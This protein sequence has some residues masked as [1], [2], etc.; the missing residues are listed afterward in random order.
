[1]LSSEGS[2]LGAIPAILLSE[3]ELE[4]CVDNW[5]QGCAAKRGGN[6]ESKTSLQFEA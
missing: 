4:T 5:S 3:W 2:A 6:S 1:V